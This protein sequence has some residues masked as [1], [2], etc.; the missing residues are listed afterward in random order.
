MET[1]DLDPVVQRVESHLQAVL[2]GSEALNGSI[3][4]KANAKLSLDASVARNPQLVPHLLPVLIQVLRTP[5]D[6]EYDQIIAL[7]ERVLAYKSYEEVL[8]FVSQ[9]DLIEGIRDGP[10]S[11]KKASIGQVLKASQADN[12]AR[13]GIVPA[14]MHVLSHRD[15]DSATAATVLHALADLSKRGDLIRQE[16]F[17]GECLHLLEDMRR[18]G[19]A[20]QQGR[21]MSLLTSI[22]PFDNPR[23]MPENLYGFPSKDLTQDRDVLLVLNKIQFYRELVENAHPDDLV[24]SIKEPIE[25]IVALWQ[26]RH[27]DTDVSAFLLSEI[28]LFFGAMSRR[29]RAY[30]RNLDTTYGITNS[31]ADSLGDRMTLSLIAVLDPDY[32]AE[33]AA[34]AIRAL[35]FKASTVR[36]LCNLV[37]GSRSYKLVEPTS[38]KV[39]SMPYLERTLFLSVLTTTPWG[40]HDLLQNWPQVVDSILH[41][42]NLTEPEVISYRR[43]ILENL[44]QLPPESLGPWDTPIR[45]AYREILHGAVDLEPQPAVASNAGG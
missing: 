18:Q 28:N 9:Q 33:F 45:Q 30:F 43:T 5:L 11:L 12:L 40:V 16:L 34:D 31:F 24:P 4:E 27:T 25:G 10:P 32:M 39:I 41:I 37:L 13:T 6:I 26:R 20:I 19:T 17:S 14:L 36:A 3:L 35:P 15:T 44:V 1:Q 23:T 38:A 8:G 42:E 22:L 2:A 29:E 21:F 7:L